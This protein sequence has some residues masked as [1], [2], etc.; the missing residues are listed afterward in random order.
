MFDSGYPFN[1]IDRKDGGTINLVSTWKYNFQTE[2]RRYIAEVEQYKLNIYIVKF[3][4]DCHSRSKNKYRLIL[5]DAKPARIIRTCINIMLH[6]YEENPLASFGFI[7]TNSSNKK[8][9]NKKIKES[10]S[11]TQRFRIYT[12]LMSAFFGKKTFSPS[13]NRK[14]SAYLMINRKCGGI[15]EFK[16]K[17]QRMFSREYVDLNFYGHQ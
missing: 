9:H 6:F 14:Y 7:G 15:R 4:A 11:N 13:Q 5:N 10:I 17:A 8:K 16:D 2:T 1:L 12:R 3:Y